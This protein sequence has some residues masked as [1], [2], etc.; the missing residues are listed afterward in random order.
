MSEG[1]RDRVRQARRLAALMLLYLA[2]AYRLSVGV[3][4][5]QL[6]AAGYVAGTDEIHA[7]IDFL[8]ET[9]LAFRRDGNVVELTARG[10][11]VA[12]GRTQATGVRRADPGELDALKT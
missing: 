10:A 1:Y 12:T 6:E 11:D 8:D 4:R 5:A 7:D 2:P 3:L 9:G